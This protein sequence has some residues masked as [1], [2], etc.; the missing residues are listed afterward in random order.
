MRMKHKLTRLDPLLLTIVG[1]GGRWVANLGRKA[2]FASLG[3]LL[4]F[5]SSKRMD[6]AFKSP[7]RMPVLRRRGVVILK[8]SV[9]SSA[10]ELGDK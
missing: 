2:H 8:N 7:I 1:K 9:K 5:V 3:R 10:D 4:L 6:L